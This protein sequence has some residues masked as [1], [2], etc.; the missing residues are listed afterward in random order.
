MD[1]KKRNEIQKKT[2]DNS[3]DLSSIDSSSLW[4]E[5][6][7]QSPNCKFTSDELKIWNAKPN[8]EK[9]EYICDVASPSPVSAEERLEF[10]N[11]NY[12]VTQE[13]TGGG[14]ILT[15]TFKRQKTKI[16]NEQ[17]SDDNIDTKIG[18]NGSKTKESK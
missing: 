16:Q 14:G 13:S 7:S 6:I 17:N 18:Y 12:V 3:S 8:K 2:V 15:F 9:L 1:N 5:R 10:C 4:N 11:S